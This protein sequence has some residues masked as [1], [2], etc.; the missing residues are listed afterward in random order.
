MLD[1]ITFRPVRL[2]LRTTGVHTSSSLLTAA[3]WCCGGV[4]S[5]D[6]GS[7]EVTPCRSARF[8]LVGPR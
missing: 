2:R 7:G 8:R 3:R 5:S 1:R 4:R 6:W